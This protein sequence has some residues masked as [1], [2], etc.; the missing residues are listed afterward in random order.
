MP[1]Y[2][3]FRLI[4]QQLN[5]YTT[6]HRKTTHHLH[7]CHLN[8]T[9]TSKGATTEIMRSIVVDI[10]VPAQT[11]NLPAGKEGQEREIK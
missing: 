3:L 6:R 1:K 8:N 5:L 4:A 2:K 9:Y 7:T 11:R 10:R